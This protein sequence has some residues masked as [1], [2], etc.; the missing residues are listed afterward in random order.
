MTQTQPRRGRGKSFQTLINELVGLV[1]AYFRQ[2][3]LAPIRG[4]GRSIALGVAGALL[5]AAGGA[6][7]VL[8]VVRAVQAETG[9]H[10]RGNL[11]WVPYV[12]GMLIAAYGAVWAA[13]RINKARR[14]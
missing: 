13:T 7:L 1:V 14:G 2:E 9:S 5:V 11:T 3:T 6:T 10:L 8:A 12:G 4:I